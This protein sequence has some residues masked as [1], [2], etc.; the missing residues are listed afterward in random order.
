[1]RSSGIREI[2]KKGMFGPLSER[3]REYSSDIFDSGTHLLA[4]INDILDLS[5]LE[6]GQFEL[7]EEDVELSVGYSASMHL[8]ETTAEKS[9]VRVSVAPG[10]DDPLLVRADDRRLRQ[11]PDQSSF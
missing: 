4:L 5:K 9:K 2:I 10:A 7:Q 1:M 6:A 3:Y 8:I 11:I